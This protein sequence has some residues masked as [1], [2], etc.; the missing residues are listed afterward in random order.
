LEKCLQIFQEIF[1]FCSECLN[2][3]AQENKSKFIQSLE[4]FSQYL[5]SS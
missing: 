5:L 4:S 1:F 2:D 3:A